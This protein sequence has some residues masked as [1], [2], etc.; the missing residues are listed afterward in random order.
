MLPEIDRLLTDSQS[1]KLEFADGEEAFSC[2]VDD[3]VL[4]W[5][6]PVAKHKLPN[7]E[8]ILLDNRANIAVVQ[9][10][11]LR[12]AIRH[13]CGPDGWHQKQELLLRLDKGSLKIGIET[14][15]GDKQE[16][17]IGAQYSGEPL[18]AGFYTRYILDFLDALGGA[19]R[20]RLAFK[21][22]QSAMEMRPD[23]DAA[24]LQWRYLVM[25]RRIS[26]EGR[27]K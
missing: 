26:E 20:V 3:R 13:V 6:S 25:P 8:A 27:S 22:A 12:E 23:G 15:K 14:T 10:S 2:R 24:E 18:T 16:S 21:D 7:Y 17:A 4:S 9:A 5:A 19:G 11:E 1:R